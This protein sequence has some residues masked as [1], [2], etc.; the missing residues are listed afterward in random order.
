MEIGGGFGGKIVPYLEPVAAILSKKTGHPVKLTMSRTDV[1]EATGP[2]SGSHIKLKMGV[3]NEGR[4]TA[5]DAR[6]IFEAGAF[7]GSPVMGAT[8]CIFTP[9]DI[10]NAR[11]E[12]YDVVLNA[13][14]TAAYRA[15]GAPSGAFAAETIIDEIC[16][17]IGMDPMDF[18][19]LNGAKEGT[20]R[21]TGPRNPRIGYLET[22]QAAKE[23]EHYSEP[24]NLPHTSGQPQD[25]QGGKTRG[26]GVATGFW[27]N[28]TGPSC[29][30]ASVNP[31]G[32]V[33]LVEGS[34]DIGGSRVAVSM[35]L[36]EVLGIPVEGC[37]TISGG[38]GLG[39]LY[40]SHGRER[41]RFQDRGSLLR[42]GAG[43]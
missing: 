33:S 15:P 25:G 22:V 41:R 24:I 37:A 39:W 36:A 42:G 1:F 40:L 21:I 5:A 3:T 43:R 2:T 38:H 27:S 30:T 20:R 7:P 35:Q 31:D 11:V 18:R 4:I 16:E 14:K 10:P 32:T 19:T 9:Y 29:A 6:L 17:K 13:P 23:H 28:N 26:R 12:G 8:M 34:P